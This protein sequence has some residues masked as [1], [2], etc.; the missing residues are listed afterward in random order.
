MN[1]KNATHLF[2]QEYPHLSEHF[3]TSVFGLF[4]LYLGGSERANSRLS[5]WRARDSRGAPWFE[6]RVGSPSLDIGRITLERLMIEPSSL[7]GS[8]LHLGFEVPPELGGI[9]PDVVVRQ[10]SGRLVL[11]ETKTIGAALNR[12]Q[13]ATYGR[14]LHFLRGRDCGAEFLLLVSVGCD[15]ATFRAALSVQ[16]ELD[17]LFGILLWEDVIKQMLQEKFSLPGI[18]IADFQRYTEAFD[19]DVA[20]SVVST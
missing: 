9:R 8:R 4:L 6:R 20:T 13:T 19:S 10:E 18:N 11:V 7:S 1:V 3:W 17:S 15:S 12:N 16:K 5:V 2:E 14:L